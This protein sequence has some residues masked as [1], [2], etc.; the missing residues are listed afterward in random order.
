MLD[1]RRGHGPAQGAYFLTYAYY[2]I[3]YALLTCRMQE[4]DGSFENVDDYKA[5]CGI[6]WLYNQP[7]QS[8]QTTIRGYTQKKGCSEETA[9]KFLG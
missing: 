9:A 8:E 5:V 1:C 3:G 6:V 4:E 2:F 7:R